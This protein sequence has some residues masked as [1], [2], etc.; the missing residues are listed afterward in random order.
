MTVGVSAT[1]CINSLHSHKADLAVNSNVSPDSYPKL[2]LIFCRISYYAFH[3]SSSQNNGGNQSSKA[4][5][6]HVTIE[7]KR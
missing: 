2:K 4:K 7:I 1:D 6:L 3:C 5:F